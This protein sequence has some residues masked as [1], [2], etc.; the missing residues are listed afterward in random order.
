MALFCKRWNQLI[1]IGCG[2]ATMTTTIAR[3]AEILDLQSNAVANGSI[4]I[5]GSTSD[6]AAV[7]YFDEDDDVEPNSP[8]DIEAVQVAHDATNIY[9]RITSLNWDTEETWRAGF[10][11]DTDVDDT[12]GYNGNF[13]AVGAEFFVEDSGVYEST[14]FTQAEWSWNPVGT[15]SRDQ[16]TLTD[17]EM[18]IPRAMIGN[19]EAFNFLVHVNNLH[20][21]A[22]SMDDVYPN[23]SDS[24]GG[25]V[26][27]YELTDVG[28]TGDFDGS[29]ALDLADVDQLAQAIAGGNFDGTFDVTGDGALNGADLTEWVSELR[30]TWFGDAN[31]DGVFDTGDLVTVFTQGKFEQDVDASWADGDWNADR[32]FGSGDLVAAFSDGGFEVGVRAAVAAVP[33]PASISLLLIGLLSVAKRRR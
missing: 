25:F 33:E 18:A 9:V 1:A 16:S 21:G 17:I 28:L 29:G 4:V 12:S 30:K 8:I 22:G 6:W 13:L 5:D 31:L 27:G 11:L 7:P 14:G 3:G 2:L 23:G 10:Y 19:P 24:I 26:Y 15:I 32:R 20:E